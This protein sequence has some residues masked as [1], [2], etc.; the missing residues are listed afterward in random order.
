MEYMI[1]RIKPEYVGEHCVQ[2]M[3]PYTEKLKIEDGEKTIFKDDKS[4]YYNNYVDDE[5]RK[6]FPFSS[7]PIHKDLNYGTT[8]TYVNVLLDYGKEYSV[9]VDNNKEA[10][11][12]KAYKDYDKAFIVETFKGSK[13]LNMT[14]EELKAH[15]IINA[16]KPRILKFLN[17]GFSKKEINSEKKK[18]KT[19]SRNKNSN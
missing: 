3:F 19:L 14:V 6:Q 5:R 16:G 1:N 8:V 7:I 4:G 11:I 17:P 13:I 15:K 2:I 18:V 10:L 12:M 9:Y